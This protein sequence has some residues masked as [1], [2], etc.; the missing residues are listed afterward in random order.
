MQRILDQGAKQGVAM[1]RAIV[2][3]SRDSDIKY[4]PNRHWEKMFLRNT[5]F[6]RDGSTTLMRVPCGT[7]RP[8]WSHPI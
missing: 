2:Y 6:E 3:A 1:S 5:T 7:T 4:W 8:S